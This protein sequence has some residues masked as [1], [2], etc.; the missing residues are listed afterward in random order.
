M[1][2]WQTTCDQQRSRLEKTEILADKLDALSGKMQNELR[3]DIIDELSAE[4]RHL[5]RQ[6]ERLR[7]KRFE[8]AVIGLEKAG[9]SALLNAWLGQQILPSEDRRCT[10][11]TTEIISV[12]TRQEQYLRIDYYRREEFEQL[13]SDK[14]AALAELKPNSREYKELDSD[15]QETEVSR[16]QIFQYIDQGN[17]SA[18]PS[19]DDIDEISDTL[20]EAVAGA[21]YTDPV[22]GKREMNRSRP[23]AI[24]RIELAT[25]THLD[26]DSKGIVFHD[27][28][29]FNSPVSKHREEA[30]QRM[31]DSDA[32]VFAKQMHMINL[33]ECETNMLK[34]ADIDRIPLEQKLFV[35]LTHADKAG[36]REQY[37]KWLDDHRNEWSTVPPQ[38]LVPVCAIAHLAK[39]RASGEV[40]RLGKISIETLQKFG[41]DDGIE[42]LKQ[43]IKT[44]IGSERSIVLRKRCDIIVSNYQKLAERILEELAPYHRDLGD[45]FD[46]EDLYVKDFNKWWGTEWIGIKQAWLNWYESEIW[47]RKGPDAAAGE[48]EKLNELRAAYNTEVDRL[49]TNLQTARPEEMQR[50]YQAHEGALAAKKAH[51]AIREKLHQ[52][53]QRELQ[54]KLPHCLTG[55]LNTISQSIVDKASDL[56]FGIAGVDE[57]LRGDQREWEKQIQYG[58]ETL[59]L[60]FGREAVDVFIRYPIDE[61]QRILGEK[62]PEIRTLEAFYKGGNNEKSNLGAYLRTGAWIIKAA[63]EIGVLPPIISKSVRAVEKTSSFNDLLYKSES[64]TDHLPI[65]AESP[66]KA[67]ASFKEVSAEIN[68]DLE[69]LRDYLKNSVFHAAGFIAHSRQELERIKENFVRVEE[70]ERGW[71][72]LVRSA[73]KRDN[74]NIPFNTAKRLQDF[75]FRREVALDIQNIQQGLQDL[76]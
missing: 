74:S 19:F 75:R 53:I 16:N 17:G 64:A 63:C 52:E 58:F 34:I 60:R 45:D 42:T 51:F 56:L 13:L 22:S 39:G 24:K 40:L 68:E 32:I 59:F 28:P 8:V 23:R 49:F 6:L 38:R 41:V 35:V 50:I 12:P 72:H 66:P 11:T 15:I 36:D 62:E 18:R 54:V 33:D 7:A 61:R 73:A 48:H 69:A 30:E 47:Q 3:P 65:D 4:R 57:S 29:G 37:D 44:Y 46:E 26:L 25:T 27:V 31:R 2:D 21:P 14:K 10:Y 76:H 5:E 9:K 43:S 20:Y 70:Q 67:A 1:S 71:D 55:S